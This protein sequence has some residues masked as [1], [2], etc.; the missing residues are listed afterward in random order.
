MKKKK[1]SQLQ[2]WAPTNSHKIDI[3]TTFKKCP[4][5]VSS[6][7][8][9]QW[10][11]LLLSLFWRGLELVPKIQMRRREAHHVTEGLVAAPLLLS[12][13]SALGLHLPTPNNKP[14]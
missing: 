10:R 8:L 11:C 6:S 7:A 4:F 1:F 5:H 14:S 12:F 3:Y 2:F 13:L 9:V